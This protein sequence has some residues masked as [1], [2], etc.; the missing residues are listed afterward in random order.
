MAKSKMDKISLLDP[1]RF[2]V[3]KNNAYVPGG[4]MNNNPM[5]AQVG[6][7]PSSLSGVNQYP[8]GD[9]GMVN[10]IQLG[11]SFPAP[12]SGK[13]QNMV[14][15]TGFQKGTGQAAPT[16]DP[17][18]QSMLES[19]HAFADASKRGLFASAL[20]ITGMPGVAPDGMGPQDLLTNSMS[21]APQGV[22]S[23]EA[24]VGKGVNM[25]T[26]KRGKA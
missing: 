10:P 18:A 6:L 24:M 2:K 19:Q 7:V 11:G 15:G 3:A 12:A 20:G 25:K 1:N 17:M 4:P 22:Q 16:P 9:S 26:G 13:P 23:A 14:S 21:V 5:N 8:Y